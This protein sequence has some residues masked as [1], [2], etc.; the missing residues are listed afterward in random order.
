MQIR[1]LRPPKG[2]AAVLKTVRDSEL[3]YG[4]VVSPGVLRPPDLLRRG[5][6]L[7]RGRHR[8]S[9]AIPRSKMT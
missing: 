4:P 7:L 6:T 2:P 9:G 3:P 1:V 5:T 8:F